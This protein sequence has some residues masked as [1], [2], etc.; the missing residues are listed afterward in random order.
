MS[1]WDQIVWIPSFD[2]YSVFIMNPVAFNV[3][4]FITLPDQ[5]VEK[6]RL[7]QLNSTQSNQ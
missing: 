1:N 2:I 6:V 5:L 7:T 3:A 4:L